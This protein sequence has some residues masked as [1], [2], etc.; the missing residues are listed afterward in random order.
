MTLDVYKDD[1]VG[2]TG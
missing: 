2:C 1:I